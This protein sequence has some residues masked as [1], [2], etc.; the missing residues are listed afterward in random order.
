MGKIVSWA[1]RWCNKTGHMHVS[2]RTTQCVMSKLY[3]W[4]CC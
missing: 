2:N 3:M 1:A 4:L